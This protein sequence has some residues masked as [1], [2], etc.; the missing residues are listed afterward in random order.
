M[1]FKI[2]MYFQLISN[3]ISFVFFIKKILILYTSYPIFENF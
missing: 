2:K 3:K 1:Y